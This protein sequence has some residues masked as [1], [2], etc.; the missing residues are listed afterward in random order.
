MSYPKGGWMAGPCPPTHPVRVPTLFFEAIFH[1]EHV[2]EHGDS[3]GKDWFYSKRVW[4]S[5]NAYFFKVY[6]LPHYT[7]QNM[8]FYKN[9]QDHSSLGLNNS[10]HMMCMFW[11]LMACRML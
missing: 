9:N 5:Q 11:K 2:F 1:T 4:N 7:I 6:T 10:V 3:L 8:I